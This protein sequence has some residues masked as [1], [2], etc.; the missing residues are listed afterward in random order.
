[1]ISK[2]KLLKMRSNA[3]VTVNFYRGILSHLVNG[4]EFKKLNMNID[5]SDHKKIIKQYSF[6][7]DKTIPNYDDDYKKYREEYQKK[8]FFGP[9]QASKF[10]GII[11]YNYVARMNILAGYIAVRSID[12]LLKEHTEFQLPNSTKDIALYL[13]EQDNSFTDQGI[14]IERSESLL[15]KFLLESI[16][17]NE[18]TNRKLNISDEEIQIISKEYYNAFA[19][20]NLDLEYKRNKKLSEINI[21]SEIFDK[22][23]NYD[24]INDTQLSSLVEA[25]FM[26]SGFAKKTL[27]M[28]LSKFVDQEIGEKQYFNLIENGNHDAFIDLLIK[29]L[30]E[31]SIIDLS[32]IRPKSVT[33]EKQDKTE[34]KLSHEIPSALDEQKVDYFDPVNVK[35]SKKENESQNPVSINKFFDLKNLDEKFGIIE[36]GIPLEEIMSK[37]ELDFL[38]LELTIVST[39]DKYANYH[40]NITSGEKRI[41]IDNDMFEKKSGFTIKADNLKLKKE[42]LLT[43]LFPAQSIN[44][45]KLLF[46]TDEKKQKVFSGDKMINLP[47]DSRYFVIKDLPDG[48]LFFVG[49]EEVQSINAHEQNNYCLGNGLYPINKLKSLTYKLQKIDNQVSFK[50]LGKITII[51]GNDCNLG[52]INLTY[53]R[54]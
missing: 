23:F 47:K 11:T 19:T 40:Q 33:V 5:L 14:S 36:D 9:E 54:P 13:I 10:D 7:A 41:F 22:L 3:I 4:S 25:L 50:K 1:M 34:K 44:N 46:A 53:M 20:F 29:K 51:S 45:S 8:T 12:I 37:Q 18:N 17:V 48:A 16:K 28:S 52:E 24:Q 49:N 43:F 6:L 39:F 31:K 27:G 2:E 32:V 35:P 26:D 15:K 38:N 30:D 42:Y 21:S